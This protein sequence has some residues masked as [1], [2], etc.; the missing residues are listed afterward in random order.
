M[1]APQR[2]PAVGR[3]YIMSRKEASNSCTV[4]TGTLFL[5]SK[6]FSVLF[7]S[8]ATHSFISTK[9]ALLLNLEGTKEEVDYQIGLPSG[10][11]IKCSM[12]YKD[13]PIMI[14]EKGIPRR[15][16]TI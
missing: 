4:V 15:F 9:A 12:F 10:Q 1:P 13:V 8:G 5:N 6:P 16:D 11:V 7:D 2:P 14:G 3:A